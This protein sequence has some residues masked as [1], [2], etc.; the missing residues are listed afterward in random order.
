MRHETSVT[1]LRRLSDLSTDELLSMCSHLQTQ[2]SAV[3]KSEG[4]E[5]PREKWEADLRFHGQATSLPVSFTFDD[6]STQG[7]DVLRRRYYFLCRS[8]STYIYYPLRFLD[9]HKQLFTF[10]LDLDVEILNIRAIAEEIIRPA[11]L[12][13]KAVR[14]ADIKEAIATRTTIVN[15]F[16]LR[17]HAK[18]TLTS[19]MAVEC[20]LMCPFT[21]AL[22]SLRAINS[23]VPVSSLRLVRMLSVELP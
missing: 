21:N 5:S 9:I 13:A 3:L 23:L 4:V 12:P 11:V 18:L 20:G 2:V 7:P 22:R 8:G 15:Y 17:S 14:Q 16:L 10:C 1:V 6:L 19:I